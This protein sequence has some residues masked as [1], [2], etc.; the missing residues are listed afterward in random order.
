MQL[1]NFQ[2]PYL[3]TVG[4]RVCLR[5]HY[6]TVTL[7]CSGIRHAWFCLISKNVL[8]GADNVKAKDGSNKKVTV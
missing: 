1:Q 5:L 8:R 3:F 7:D 6:M 2:N 4:Q